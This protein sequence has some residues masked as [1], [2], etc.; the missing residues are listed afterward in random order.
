M[1]TIEELNTENQL[2]PAV[3]HTRDKSDYDALI[4]NFSIDKIAGQV[5]IVHGLTSESQMALLRAAS[6][7]T[8]I[9]TTGLP[10]DIA[11]QL[12]EIMVI[13]SW[14]KERPD[15]TRTRGCTAPATYCVRKVIATQEAAEAYAR[16]KESPDFK[17]AFGAGE[18]DSEAF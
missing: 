16:L 7:G 1:N 15:G 8:R 13:R 6:K 11:S 5:K 2:P 14:D 12:G 17:E 9:V 10:V 4:S 18:A 3:L